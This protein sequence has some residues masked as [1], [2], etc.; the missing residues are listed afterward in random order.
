M[1]TAVRKTRLTALTLAIISLPVLASA[2][3]ACTTYTVSDGDTLGSIAQAA[4]G[5]FDYQMIFNANRDA[6]AANPNSLP[7]GLQLILP[8]EDGRLT[9]DSELSSVIEAET[10]KQES[11][12]KKSNVYEPPL[13]FVTSNNWMPFTDESLTGGGIFVRMAATAMQRGGNDRDHQV[14][15]VD[16]WMSHIDVLLPSGAFD[17]SIAWESPDCSK[18]DMLGEFSARMCTEF[19]FSLPIYETAY[20][21]NTLVDS[22]YADARAFSDYAGA[23]ICRPEAWPMGDLEVQGLAPPVVEIVQPKNPIDC[24]ELLLKGEVDVYSIEAETSTSN[25]TELNGV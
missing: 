11:T 2:Q 24:A 12:A 15:Y 4:Y 16:D 13:K 6:L 18:L 23:K 20:S 10:E 1:T 9:P 5:T 22:K 8:C 19:D 21:F 14:S 25:F 17:I 7:A 3:E